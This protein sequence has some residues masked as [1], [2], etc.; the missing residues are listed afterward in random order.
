M[1]QIGVK[2]LPQEDRPS[3]KVNLQNFL[4]SFRVISQ[5]K[6]IAAPRIND[7]ELFTFEWRLYKNVIQWDPIENIKCSELIDTWTDLPQKERKMLKKEIPNRSQL[8]PNITEFYMLTNPEP[9]KWLELKIKP[10]EAGDQFNGI[11]MIQSADIRRYFDPQFYNNNGY[12][13]AISHE[14]LIYME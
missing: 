5:E 7:E 10:T 6:G 1:Q 4:P 11:S 14:D 9:N 13:E 8:C 3:Y 12:L 2:Y